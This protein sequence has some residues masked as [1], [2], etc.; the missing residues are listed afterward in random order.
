MIIQA[1]VGYSF[2]P[3]VAPQDDDLERGVGDKLVVTPWN[4]DLER[5]VGD[6]LVITPQGIDLIALQTPTPLQSPFPTWV[7]QSRWSSI[8]AKFFFQ[9]MNLCRIL[10]TKTF[11]LTVVMNWRVIIYNKITKSVSSFFLIISIKIYRYIQRFYFSRN[12]SCS[13]L[14]LECRGFKDMLKYCNSCIL[15]IISIFVVE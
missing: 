5:G 14:F 13:K 8:L 11:M 7:C 4:N 1:R 2:H 9:L 12:F 3:V 15:L 6:K 10:V